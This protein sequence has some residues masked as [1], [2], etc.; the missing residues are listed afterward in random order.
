MTDIYSDCVTL[1]ECVQLRAEAVKRQSRETD[2]GVV[3]DYIER[4]YM[5]ICNYLSCDELPRRLTPAVGALAPILIVHT[6][7]SNNGYV[8]SKT[9]GSRSVS[10][11]YGDGTKLD[12]Y[13]LTAEVR[14]MLP[15]P[16][17]RCF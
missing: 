16:R 15:L 3:R 4:A 12:E 14:A 5:S 6:S 9:Q 10:F 7:Q 1:E 8:A 17:L 2:D 11:S 13:G